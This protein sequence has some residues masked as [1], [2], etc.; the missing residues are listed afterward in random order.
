[1]EQQI[2]YI[3]EETV[4]LKELF[5]TLKAH[6]KLI[7]GI[8]ALF[9]IIALAYIF[10]AKPVYEVKGLI[11]TATINKKPV[12]NI[13]DLKQKVETIF[14]VN[15]KGKK[16]ELPIVKDV[17]IPKKSEGILVVKTH[18]YSNESAQKKLQEVI[19]YVTTLQNKEL[20]V[21]IEGQKQKLQLVNKD[22]KRNQELAVSIDEIIHSNQDQ[23][24]KISK[25]DAALAGIYTIEISKKQ[26]ELNKVKD[27]IFALKSKRT[28][29]EL[30][31]SP[32]KIQATKLVGK[33]V[34]L[35]KPVKPK[36]ALIVIIAFI[37]GLMLSI[38]IALFIEFLENQKT[39]N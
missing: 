39:E 32:L 7:W 16:I 10:L 27:K 35:D 3:E 29:I 8:T 34:I 15:L 6:K 2:P 28:D 22:I 9:T 11:E 1:L 31:T 5:K 25:E 18:G 19:D 23:L 24:L 36:K 21:Y 37:T 20:G 13:H 14:E 17:S 26:T 12:Q 38:F 30:S 4:D 33:P